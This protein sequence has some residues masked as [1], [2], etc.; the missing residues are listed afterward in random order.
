[1]HNLKK[2]SPIIHKD[3]KIFQAINKIIKSKIKILFV[4]DK[5]NKL[6]GSVSSGDIRRSIIKKIDPNLPVHKLMFTKPKY[7]LKNNKIP[8][9]KESLVCSTRLIQLLL[10]K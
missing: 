6:L 5:N 1:M 9:L 7:L 8:L 4:V 2:N 10:L 3:Q